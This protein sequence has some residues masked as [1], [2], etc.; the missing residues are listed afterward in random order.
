LKNPTKIEN[1]EG[2]E[3]IH[4][5]IIHIPKFEN[6]NIYFKNRVVEFLGEMF[7]WCMILME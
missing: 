5:K 4:D 7:L 1:F 6:L 2:M 3:Y